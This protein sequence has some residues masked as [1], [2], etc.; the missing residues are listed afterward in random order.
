[1]I[2]IT[3]YIILIGLLVW[4]ILGARGKWWLKLLAIFVTFSFSFLLFNAM[5]SY[6]GWAS[7][8][9]IPKQSQFV[10][11]IVS[12]PSPLNNNQGII[13]LWVIPLESNHNIFD[14]Q[15]KSGE[16]RAY[17]VPYSK[18]LENVIT[19]AQ[20]L[21]NGSKSS[22]KGQIGSNALIIHA[23]GKWAVHKFNISPLPPKSH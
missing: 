3:T 12:Q 5:D 15:S 17:K 14:Y 16:P 18:S 21:M 23:D 13:Y 6:K 1:M 22:P 4:N 2:L 8:D 20:K 10:A 11:G 7:A 9:T 19:E